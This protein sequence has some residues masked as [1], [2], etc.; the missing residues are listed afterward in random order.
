MASTAIYGLFWIYLGTLLNTESYGEVNYYLSISIIAS[1][2]S[3]LG[4]ENTLL[5]YITKDKRVVPVFLVITI[6]SSTVSSTILFILF[7]NIAMSLYVIGSAIFGLVSNIML[8]EKRYKQYS[9]C[10]ISQRILLIPLSLGLY[11]IMGPNGIILGLGLASFPFSFLLYNELKGKKID[12]S[13]LKPH[14][15]FI[16]TSFILSTSRTANSYLDRLIVFPLFGFSLLGNYSLGLQY[17]TLL[18]LVPQIV[19]LYV[20]PHDTAGKTNQKIKLGTVLISIVIAVIGIVLTP[21]V[22]PNIFPKFTEA[23]GIIQ[24]I[25]IAII[26]ISINAMYISKFLANGLIRY[27]TIGSGIYLITQVFA[28]VL[29]GKIYGINGAAAALDLATILESIFLIIV[30]KQIKVS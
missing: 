21:L 2:I 7:H 25:S 15:S 1:V 10:V 12:I 18:G 20:L 4:A 5:V 14:S 16:G 11:I 22:V 29:L 28:I 17:L 13:L 6:V 3:L 26:P 19:Y 30:N 8:G 24:I 23:V 9:L 27:V